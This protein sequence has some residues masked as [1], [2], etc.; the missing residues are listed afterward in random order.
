MD[1]QLKRILNIVRQTGDRII[2]TDTNGKDAYVVMGL[3]AYEALM[4]NPEEKNEISS[5]TVESPGEN[6]DLLPPV[7]EKKEEISSDSKRIWDVLPTNKDVST[8]D[9]NQ[10]TSEERQV[11][12][13]V[14]QRLNHSPSVSEP[15]V[16]SV[17][18]SREEF[19]KKQTNSLGEDLEGGEEQF[20]LEPIE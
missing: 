14:F 13:Q 9:Q 5:I 11:L 7:Q 10:L 4:L 1:F 2:V 8:W 6:L 3:D 19:S 20:Y 16:K 15:V 12:A 17:E 18:T